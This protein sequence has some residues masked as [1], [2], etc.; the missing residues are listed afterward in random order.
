MYA[1]CVSKVHLKK[2]RVMARIIRCGSDFYHGP[3]PC[4][5]CKI[6]LESEAKE[7]KRLLREGV[8]Y[9]HCSYHGRYQPH[10]GEMNCPRCLYLYRRD[11][12]FSKW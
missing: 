2:E 8:P 11:G 3:A 10:R 9:A 7:N 12:T 6:Y 1:A 4:P 5:K